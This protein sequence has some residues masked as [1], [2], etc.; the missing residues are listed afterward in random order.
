VTSRRLAAAN[1]RNARK[2]TGPRTAEGKLKAARNALRHGFVVP[3]LADPA[4]AKDIVELA[5]RFAD[6]SKD[7][8]MRALAVDVAA[9]QVDVERVRHARYDLIA[10]RAIGADEIRQLCTL[11]RY[12]RL[13][14]W[15]RKLAARAWQAALFDSIG[16]AQ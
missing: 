4:L 9:A 7:P 2:S 16:S 6:G 12:E 5:E 1:R 13:A 15:R 3:V 14:A 10:R 11:V 8:R